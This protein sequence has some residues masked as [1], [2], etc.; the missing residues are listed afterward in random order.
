MF[1]GWDGFYMLLGSA[2]AGLIGLVF[3]VV[4]LT[5]GFERE[6][7][8][9]GS[10]RFMTPTV[11]QFAVVLLVSAIASAPIGAGLARLGLIVVSLAALA[12][13]AR[14]AYRMFVGDG[15][16]PTHWSDPWS[17]GAAPAAAYVILAVT[18]AAGWALGVGVMAMGILLCGV[19]NAWDLITYIAPMRSAGGDA[20]SGGGASDGGATPPPE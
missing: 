15:Q 19:R 10:S 6:R 5:A 7:A 18:A 9:W 2:S 17:Y 14:N 13:A 3:I 4:T 16:P 1:Q 11:L 20:G 8:L 12:H